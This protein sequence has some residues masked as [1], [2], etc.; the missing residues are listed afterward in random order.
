MDII[1]EVA[2]EAGIS[3]E[4]DHPGGKIGRSKLQLTSFFLKN[5]TA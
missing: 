2:R 3:E 1:S 5:R 4:V